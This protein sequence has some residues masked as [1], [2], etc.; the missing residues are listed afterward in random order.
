MAAK[1]T[2]FEPK[3]VPPGTVLPPLQIAPLGAPPKSKPKLNDWLADHPNVASAIVWEQLLPVGK[4][5]GKASVAWPDWSAIQRQRLQLRFDDYWEWY[6]S[7]ATWYNAFWL[8][9]SKGPSTT[10]SPSV[11][12]D[13]DPKPVDDPPANL[14]VSS[15]AQA[16]PTILSAKDAFELYVRYVAL[17]LVVE[18]GS[19]VPWSLADYSKAMLLELLDGRTTFSWIDKGDTVADGGD[20]VSVQA[21]GYVIKLA[22]TPGPPLIAASF[23]GLNALIGVTQLVTIGALLEWA[24]A[25][26]HCIDTGATATGSMQYWQ[27]VGCAPMSRMIR[28]TIDGSGAYQGVRHWTVGCFGTSWFFKHALRTLNIPVQVI[29][30]N[31]TSPYFMSKEKYLTHGDD[32]YMIWESRPTPTPGSKLLINKTQFT[33]W[34][35]TSSN[36]SLHVGR[37]PKDLAVE[38]LP[39][40]LLRRYCQDKADQASARKSVVQL[41]AESQ[42]YEFFYE[43]VA[44]GHIYSVPDLDALHLWERLAA[45]A[46]DCLPPAPAA[47][48]S[49]ADG[50]MGQSLTPT[51]TW[52]QSGPPNCSFALRLWV[53]DNAAGASG[54]TEF[55]LQAKK[56]FKVPAKLLLPNTVYS[57][58]VVA[59]NFKGNVDSPI[60]SFKTGD[61]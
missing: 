36:S 23:M 46:G 2:S 26:E 44:K 14:Q 37:R 47:L 43:P 10:F 21:S 33:E 22:V 57:W 15:G 32:P 28:G 5:G 24:K 59:R 20:P 56:K 52:E 9:Q 7:F 34:F 19:Y 6:K 27:Y 11:D 35:K 39:D 3:F 12:V 40:E 31:H 53:A 48:L 55:A 1:M 17:S 45:K 42:V 13:A 50:S 8:N 61:K 18:L 25:L 29:V 41:K 16:A 54:A 60:F 38:Y 30:P 49:P 4:G 51:L 58:K